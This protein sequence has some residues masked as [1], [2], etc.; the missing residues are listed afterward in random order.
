LIAGCPFCAIAA[1]IDATVEVIWEDNT[2]V[3]FFPDS[4]ATPGHTLII[5]RVHVPNLWEAPGS[6]AADLILAAHFVGRAI[7][8]ALTPEGMNLISAA[9][10]VA[11]QSVPHL[12]LHIVPRWLGDSIDPIWPAK[13]PQDAGEMHRLADELRRA[14]TNLADR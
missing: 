6:L 10:S 7:A 4:P 8:S 1:G 14:I 12:H 9:G 11:E 5:P 2:L 13:R 3:A